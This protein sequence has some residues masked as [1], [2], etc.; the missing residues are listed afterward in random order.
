MP[1]YITRCNVPIEDPGS[2]GGKRPC[3]AEIVITAG[4]KPP[5]LG[6]APETKT[7]AFVQAIVG[8]LMKKHPPLAAAAMNM[9]E[10]FL[11]FQVV[12]FTMSADPGCVQFMASFADALCRM[13]TLPVSD[14]AIE[15]VVAMMG[16]TMD[17]P[18]RS[19]VIQAMQYVRNF[20]LRKIAQQQP[21]GIANG[22]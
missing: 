17:D 6:E 13:S 15:E 11:A 4:I 21:V 7:K 22:Q 2:P 3:G 12:G 20:Q 9:M 8:H 1:K 16:F 19:K 14:R 18:Q 5:E 10:Q